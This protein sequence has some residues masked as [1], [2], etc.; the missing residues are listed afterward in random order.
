[1]ASKKIYSYEMMTTIFD[2]LFSI[3][4]ILA[5]LAFFIWFFW[6]VGSAF[7]SNQLPDK[8]GLH[9]NE[10]GAIFG[11][12]IGLALIFYYLYLTRGH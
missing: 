5:I 10:I 8:G 9:G 11:L 6:A 1:M 12:V 4:A 3:F 7:E 2:S